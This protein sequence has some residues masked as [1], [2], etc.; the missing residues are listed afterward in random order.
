M[1]EL[2]EL[3]AEWRE[4]ERQLE[5]GLDRELARRLDDLRAEHARL[6]SG[7]SRPRFASVRGLDPPAS[8]SATDSRRFPETPPTPAVASVTPTDKSKPSRLAAWRRR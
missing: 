6:V 4:R 2:V 1:G 5:A 3:V 7:F 8:T